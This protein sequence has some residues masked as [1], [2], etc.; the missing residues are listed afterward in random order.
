MKHL[1][2]KLSVLA[3]ACLGAG[4]LTLQPTAYAKA[5]DGPEG[6]LTMQNGAAV[7]VSDD[8]SGIRWTTKIDFDK[9]QML[10]G[11]D[12]TITFG[13]LVLPTDS[14][15]DD[16]VL[17]EADKA[18]GAVDIVANIDVANIAN[19]TEYYSIINYDNL[20]E[21]FANEA[22]PEEALQKAYALELTARSYV[23]VN[24]SYYF[25][26]MTGIS[27][28]RS[29]RQ[30]ALAAELAGDWT[31][32][33]E[34]KATKAATYYGMTERYVPEKVSNGAAG[35]KYINLN[36]GATP[37]QTVKMVI[38]LDG[39]VESLFVGA[40][41]VEYVSYEAAEEGS[42]TKVLTFK[43]AEG[44]TF[45]TG[46]TY[47]TIFTDKGFVTEP[48][49]GATKVMKKISDFEIF[50]AIRENLNVN[51]SGDK[52]IYYGAPTTDPEK[53]MSKYKLDGYYVL[54]KDLTFDAEKDTVIKDADGY[55]GKGWYGVGG[56]VGTGLG[57]T[58]TFNGLGNWIRGYEDA[59]GN[60]GLLQLVNGGT[61]KNIYMYAYKH[62]VTTTVDKTTTNEET[63]ET[64]TT[65]EQTTTY[66][67]ATG[68]LAY[69]MIDPT[70]ENVFVYNKY[71]S[72]QHSQY[73]LAS[74]LYQTEA[75]AAKLS[76][77]YI[78]AEYTNLSSSKNKG[79][80]FGN[81]AGKTQ[82]EYNWNN[83]Y[84]TGALGAHYVAKTK[85]AIMVD[86]AQ[87][88]VYLPD[89]TAIAESQKT[90]NGYTYYAPDY[91]GAPVELTLVEGG[92]TGT[93]TYK[94]VVYNIYKTSNDPTSTTLDA[95]AKAPMLLNGV[96]VYYTN[97]DFQAAAPNLDFS[98]FTGVNGANCWTVNAENGTLVWNG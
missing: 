93:L 39:A 98:G 73:A 23:N 45:P 64:T 86:G 56:F 54:A 67:K 96:Y 77:L 85:Y 49:I 68:D 10:C 18:A 79:G 92:M 55:E 4:A 37:E 38:E 90:E 32:E 76:N 3:L 26:D 88:A 82:A 70:I 47:L 75:D 25:T 24:G 31:D 80:L 33:Q 16:G 35:T 62:S 81:Y 72:A 78:R 41:R 48:I 94:D 9:Y 58:G 44:Q 8:F 71:L 13:T 12:K 69:Y 1:K 74:Y 57:L 7:Y 21:A 29:A 63:G 66:A 51:S 87:K 22:N 17:T 5:E 50:S 59:R 97:T 15:G 34:A 42:E 84:V 53:D 6:C 43:V 46:E 83:V 2:I 89:F 27:T 40:E 36:N 61:I 11:A 95:L 30:V 91:K 20:A 19:D 28:S 60:S 14:L 65:Q 52:K